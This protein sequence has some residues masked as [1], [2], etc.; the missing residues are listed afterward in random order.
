MA[1]EGGKTVAEADPEVSE[2]ID[3]A[4]YY[5]DRAIELDRPAGMRAPT[6]LAS[7]RPR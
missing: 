1:A 7:R 2:A 5:A 3:F 6:A 4:R